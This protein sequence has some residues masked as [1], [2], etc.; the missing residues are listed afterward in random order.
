MIFGVAPVARPGDSVTV[1]VGGDGGFTADSPNYDQATVSSMREI[2]DLSNLDNSLWITTTGE[3][4]EPYSG[5]Y[6]D[7]IALWDQNKY[8]QMNYTPS[9]LA[10]THV[11]VLVLKP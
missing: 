9:A 8:E 6:S 10:R 5:H 4:G 3:S 7:L 2:I 11:K 1:N